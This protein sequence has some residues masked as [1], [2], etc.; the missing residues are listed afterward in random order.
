ME[1]TV[2]GFC[3]TSVPNELF[4]NNKKTVKGDT[5]DGIFDIFDRYNFTV[6]EDEP[7]E[8][9]VAIDPELLGK[10][11]EKF[12]AIRPDNFNEYIKVLNLS[13][14]GLPKAGRGKKG[15]ENKFNKQYGVYYTPREIVH[16]MCRE[17][18][19]NYLASEFS[20]PAEASAKAD[21]LDS[22]SSKAGIS[23]PPLGETERGLAF[24]PKEDIETLINYGELLGENEAVVVRRLA[25]KG[26]ETETYY[27]KLPESIRKNA[28]LI[29]EKLADILICDPAVGSGA[30]PVG[31]MHEIVNTRNILSIFIK[32]KNR[33]IY[34]FKRECIEKSLFGVDIDS[35]AVEIAKLRLWL[36]LVVDE[37]DFKEI[38]PLPNLDYKIVRGNSLIGFP[39]DWKSSIS[40]IIENLKKEYFT[41]TR[42]QH[43]AILKEEIENQI[44]S[45]LE[46]SQKNFGYKVDFDFKTFLSEV[47]HQ[48]KGFDIVIANP[49]YVFG[50]N[51]GI[52][53]QEKKT[54]KKLYFS[55]S[56]KINLFSIFIEKG[57]KL[58]K[59][60]GFLSYIV[61][62]TLLRVTSYSNIREYIIRNTKIPEIV[63]LDVGVFENV[64][65]STIIISIEKTVTDLSNKIL[66]RRGIENPKPSNVLYQKAFD[67]KGYIFN[68]F[69]SQ[70][71][72]KI[73]D[74]LKENSIPLGELTKFIRF[75]V[76]ITNNINKV[77]GNKKFDNNWKPFLEGNEIGAYNIVY[78][79]RYLH[80][81]KNLLHRSRTP[82]VFE[83]NKILIQR[84]TG[85]SN[86]IK[87]AFDTNQFYNK[88]S[89]I[90][91]ILIDNNEEHYKYILGILNSS[92]INWFYNNNYT[93]ESKLTVNLSKEY[94]SEIPI[95]KLDKEKLQC[96]IIRLVTTILKARQ[97]NPQAN[98]KHLEDQ[99]D[100][101]VYNPRRTTTSPTKK[102]R[103]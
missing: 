8:K 60:E 32:D 41:E 103:L 53:D 45:R 71:N 63:D 91:L 67:N 35:G 19:I 42:P 99:I 89:I 44:M 21:A 37:D 73:I 50:G 18:L 9:E 98:T 59:P 61:P 28:K 11:Y 100:I 62:N 88:E 74:K 39:E 72:K 92:L 34:K 46:N 70:Q 4:S 47:F 13:A 2:Y 20:L 52:T 65:A 76:V 43:K 90:N 85:G 49:P 77:V 101:I 66:I 97:Q 87:A 54:F 12:N 95:K 68:I 84:I 93:N 48:K 22:T 64:T 78:Q 31:M 40:E 6:I 15:E 3:V 30:F 83:T 51:K 55:G 80:Y 81:K 24:I 102:L 75:G 26:K 17:S 16:Y 7:L 57:T 25:D 36:S 56:R 27:H 94:L 69:S 14:E 33:T 86:P 5:G 29:D 82:E 58:L 1:F 38:K 10:A 79:G 23:S 96:E